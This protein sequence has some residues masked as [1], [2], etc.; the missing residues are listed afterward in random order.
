MLELALTSM[1][2]S[3]YSLG[4]TCWTECG[5][6]ASES[7]SRQTVCPLDTADSI[8]L[9][10][11]TIGGIPTNAS[12]AV[13]RRL[14]PGARDTLLLGESED[15]PGVVFSFPSFTAVAIQW[16]PKMNWLRLHLTVELN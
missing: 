1:L 8:L 10:E 13:L 6:P 11:E 14:C 7:Q 15:T 16:E 9:T 12:F 4:S 3:S 5:W 2:L